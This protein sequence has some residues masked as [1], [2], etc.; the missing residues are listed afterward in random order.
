MMP[1]AVTLM[2]V[3]PLSSRIVE[4]AGTKRVV[5]T[6][7]AFVAIALAL[8]VG[9][10]VDSSYGDVVWRMMFLAVGM[11]LV[12]A[13]ATESIMGSLPLGKAGVGSAVNDTTRQVGGALGI[14]VIGSVLSSMHG[15]KIAEALSGSGLPDAA[16]E[17]A[18]NSLGGA[19]AIADGVGGET[20]AQMA[21][22][23]KSAFVSALHGGAIVAAVAAALG[24]VVVAIYLPSHA[25]EHAD[26]PAGDV[27]DLTSR[28]A[29]AEYPEAVQ[30]QPVAGR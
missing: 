2:I 13:P 25:P 16:V 27:A 19:L 9:L 1:L 7:L 4:R 29:T 28:L 12:M 11:G 15:S 6:G 20:G 24:A 30:H 22:A 5:G 10:Q 8:N 17:A 14:A 26:A 21:G 3:A 23:A 18:R